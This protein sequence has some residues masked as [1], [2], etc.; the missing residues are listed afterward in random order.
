MTINRT[1]LKNLEKNLKPCPEC[2]CTKIN[3]SID[4]SRKI[5]RWVI[6]C[7]NCDEEVRSISLRYAIHEWD[8]WAELCELNKRYNL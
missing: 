8:V 1:R 2:E 4:R 5:K 7:S 3:I 6:S